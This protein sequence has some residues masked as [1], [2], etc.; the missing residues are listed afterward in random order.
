M[1]QTAQRQSTS[2]PAP[3]GH[4]A[5]VMRLERE[6]SDIPSRNELVNAAERIISAYPNARPADPQ[7]YVDAMVAYLAQFPRSV[8]EQVCDPGNGVVTRC[9]FPP[10]IAEVEEFARPIMSR[11]G[12]RL[13]RERRVVEQL[14]A[15]REGPTK[16]ER[17]AVGKQVKEL[18]ASMSADESVTPEWLLPENQQSDLHKRM[19]ERF[20][21]TQCK[22]GEAIRAHLASQNAVEDA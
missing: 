4:K 9:I 6:L 15:R 5:E 12:G 2:L 20:A 14:E 17:E 19:T 21:R 1:N 7:G 10:T 16:Q 8:L 3:E 18:A 22:S 13:E 11:L